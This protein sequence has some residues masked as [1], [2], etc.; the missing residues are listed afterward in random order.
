MWIAWS[1]IYGFF[2]T[3]GAGKL[4]VDKTFY[5]SDLR[6]TRKTLKEIKFPKNL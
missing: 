5:S 1:T 3:E 2:K 6:E 4:K